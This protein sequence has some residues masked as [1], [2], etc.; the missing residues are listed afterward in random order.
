MCL[1]SF[2]QGLEPF[3][4]IKKEKF[5]N[6]LSLSNTIYFKN[7]TAPSIYFFYICFSHMFQ[8]SLLLTSFLDSHANSYS[9]A[10]DLIFIAM[11]KSSHV[12]SQTSLG[13]C[14]HFSEAIF[15]NNE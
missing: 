2:S 1:R 8:N 14:A 4:S 13:C 12:Y 7:N 11:L 5:S 10:D 15:L 9:F 3:H 6:H